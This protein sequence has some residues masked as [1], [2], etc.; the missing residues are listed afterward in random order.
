[1][2]ADVKP[3]VGDAFITT[4]ELNKPF[5]A[6]ETVKFKA[7][8]DNRRIQFVNIEYVDNRS[9]PIT[10]TQVV[11]GTTTTVWFEMNVLSSSFYIRDVFDLY[12]RSSNAYVDFDTSQH[13]TLEMEELILKDNITPELIETPIVKSNERTYSP[14]YTLYVNPTT[15]FT[16]NI[17]TTMDLSLNLPVSNHDVIN[18]VQVRITIDPTKMTNITSQTPLS[19]SGNSYTYEISGFSTPE[20]NLTD[21]FTFNLR[22]FDRKI[23]FDETDM[24]VELISVTYQN[25]P[26]TISSYLTSSWTGQVK[27]QIWMSASLEQ[28]L[29]AID[30]SLNGTWASN[31][32]LTI[33]FDS[34]HHDIIGSSLY[35]SDDYG[36]GLSNTRIYTQYLLGV[37]E[38]L[39]FDTPNV[40]IEQDTLYHS[41]LNQDIKVFVSHPNKDSSDTI[42]AT[43]YPGNKFKSHFKLFAENPTIDEDN[44]YTVELWV[45]KE[46]DAVLEYMEITPVFNSSRII[47]LNFIEKNVPDITNK[48]GNNLIYDNSSLLYRLSNPINN[49]YKLGKWRFQ[50]LK[51]TSSATDLQIGFTI[52]PA[53]FRLNKPP[54]YSSIATYFNRNFTS[55][56]DTLSYVPRINLRLN[57]Y[58]SAPYIY[59]DLYADIGFSG[60]STFAIRVNM[61]GSYVY[62]TQYADSTI[63]T[64]RL[65]NTSVEYTYLEN[66]PDATT[67]KGEILLA[68]IAVASG[69]LET[70]E[71]NFTHFVP[72]SVLGYAFT[73][74]KNDFST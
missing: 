63:S 56:D 54:L 21:F 8:L 59:V 34:T 49:R 16:P 69:E 47:V 5:T 39:F 26:V 74:S 31:T 62:A 58:E 29:K 61:L 13:L 25:E 17:E 55:I 73:Y 57:I 20:T 72:T 18:T 64:N 33:V 14:T 45:S 65:S 7:I 2:K 15:T 19:T 37:N 24:T 66:I 22:Q 27:P 4:L 38:T 70:T 52:T 46:A 11:S 48:S 68:S 40:D 60:I 3:P 44:I 35:G 51:P 23:G 71:E 30:L 67:D 36:W 6:F 42:Y 43:L 50:V 12:L 32:Q 10:S 1:M 53:S 9:Q 28:T 41:K